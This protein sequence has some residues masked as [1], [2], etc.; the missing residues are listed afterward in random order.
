MQEAEMERGKNRERREEKLTAPLLPSAIT[1]VRTGE[2]ERQRGAYAWSSAARQR[3]RYIT[4]VFKLTRC[5]LRTVDLRERAPVRSGAA[6]VR[7]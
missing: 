6:S 3:D 5:A 4:R 7:R 1:E 2:E